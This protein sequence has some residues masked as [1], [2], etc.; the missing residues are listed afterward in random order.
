MSRDEAVSAGLV[1]AFASLVTA[2]VT[3]VAGL[4]GRPPRWRALAGLLVFPLALLWARDE[5]MHRRV[6]VWV[7]S[8]AVYAVLL[9]LASR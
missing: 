8:A 6:V 7:T 9:W 5:R 4:A 1:V 3:L 2:H